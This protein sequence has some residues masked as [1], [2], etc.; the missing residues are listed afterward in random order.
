VSNQQK[1]AQFDA[2][3]SERT[4]TQNLTASQAALVAIAA[5][6]ARLRERFD[7]LDTYVR[8]E[9]S[10]CRRA[11]WLDLGGIE[12]EEIERCADVE[13]DF[14]T[15]YGVHA[16]GT[17]HALKDCDAFIDAQDYLEALV[18]GLPEQVAA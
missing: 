18:A 3:A 5:L 14:F 4:P 16:D 8:F 9:L 6:H 1:A 7:D 15:V 13:A 12:C 11:G 10:G 17:S 2:P